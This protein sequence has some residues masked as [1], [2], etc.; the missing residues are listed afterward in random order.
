MDC[1]NAKALFRLGQ[2]YGALNFYDQAIVSFK[3]ALEIFPNEKK[4]LIELKK[5]E[6]AQKQ[7]LIIEKKMCS[8][9]LTY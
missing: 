8:K 5:I 4:F 9:M 2:A 7:Y 6:H 1:K 3:K